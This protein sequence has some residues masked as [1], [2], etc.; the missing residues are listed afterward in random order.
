MTLG[1]GSVYSSQSLYVGGGYDGG[2]GV[3]VTA[4]G[5]AWLSGQLVADAGISVGRGVFT[6]AGDGTGHVATGGTLSVAAS[7]SFGGDVSIGDDDGW[8]DLANT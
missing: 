5:S 7:A 3:T 8:G 2:S 6:V 4:N 1:N